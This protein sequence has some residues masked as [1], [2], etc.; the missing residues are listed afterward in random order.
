LFYILI[1]L[2]LSF[3]PAVPVIIGFPIIF[4]KK[5][6]VQVFEISDLSTQLYVQICLAFVGGFIHLFFA[7][8]KDSKSLNKTEIKRESEA[9]PATTTIIGS[10]IFAIDSDFF[11][12]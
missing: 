9:S 10:F 4:Y 5:S 8:L 12:F 6:F 11:R 1:F 2:S 3:A 7:I